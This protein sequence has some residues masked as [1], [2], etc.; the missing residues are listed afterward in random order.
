MWRASPQYCQIVRYAGSLITLFTDL[1]H[2]VND[3]RQIEIHKAEPLVS[4]PSASEFQLVVEKLK[5]HRSPVLIKSQQNWLWQGGDQL[6]MRSINFSI[7][8]GIWRNSLWSGSSRSLYLS[9]RSVIKQIVVIIEAYHFANYK[10]NFVQHP[11]VKV[12]SICRG[13]YWGSSVWILTQQVNYWSYIL[14]SSNTCER[15][16]NTMKQCISCL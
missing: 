10:Q 2:G 14:H 11:A 16:G 3:V 7:I 12:N 6:D 8:F 4:K 1:V 5:N 15:N 9:V 13:N